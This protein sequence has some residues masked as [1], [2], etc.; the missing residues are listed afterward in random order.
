M[1]ELLEK[2]SQQ[3]KTLHNGIKTYIN[4]S[5][6]KLMSAIP[7]DKTNQEVEI[8]IDRPIINEQPFDIKQTLIV[9]F[10][11]EMFTV[12]FVDSYLLSDYKGGLLRFIAD[13]IEAIDYCQRFM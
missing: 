7:Y 8:P 5:F 1:E 12:W 2:K 9:S 10:Y 6:D 4:H 3:T 13:V 11:G